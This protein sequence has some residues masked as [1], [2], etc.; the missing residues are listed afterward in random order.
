MYDRTA[1]WTYGHREHTGTRQLELRTARPGSGMASEFKAVR[2]SLDTS[3]KPAPGKDGG[4]LYDHVN[5]SLKHAA[6]EWLEQ[7]HSALIR[8]GWQLLAIEGE[9]EVIPLHA[10][11]VGA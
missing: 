10:A 7:Q 9:A 8:A 3:G 6:V 4:S 1:L 11:Q 5:K 2:T